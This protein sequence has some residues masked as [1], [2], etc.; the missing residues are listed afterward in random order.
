MYGML[1]ICEVQNKDAVSF[2]LQIDF[3]H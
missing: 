2:A 1:H 3:R